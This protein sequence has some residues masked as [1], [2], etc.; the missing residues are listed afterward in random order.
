MWV[1]EAAWGPDRQLFISHDKDEFNSKYHWRLS[2]SSEQ[3]NDMIC[4]IFYKHSNQ[5]EFKSPLIVSHFYLSSLVHKFNWFI[6]LHVFILLFPAPSQILPTLPYTYMDHHNR[7][8]A[9][10]PASTFSK[11]KLIL[12]KY[13]TDPQKIPAC[14]CHFSAL[15]TYSLLAIELSS[16]LSFSIQ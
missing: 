14:F 16:N 3:S 8:L 7:L 10:I 4:F 12:Q 11:V 13:Q 5:Q 15:E 9:D 1:R 6:L 2:E